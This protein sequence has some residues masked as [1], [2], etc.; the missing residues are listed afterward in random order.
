MRAPQPTSV[1]HVEPLLAEPV[2]LRAGGVAVATAGAVAAR[3]VRWRTAE[4][5]L[6][7]ATPGDVLAAVR[8]TSRTRNSARVGPT[9]CGRDHWCIRAS[10]AL[11]SRAQATRRPL[12]DR[13]RS[14]GVRPSDLVSGATEPREPHRAFPSP[15]LS[16]SRRTRPRRRD[17]RRPPGHPGGRG[18]DAMARRSRAV[19]ERS[20]HDHTG[21][22][23]GPRCR[24]GVVG[25]VPPAWLP[26]WWQ[27]A[28][29]APVWGSIAPSAG[30]AASRPGAA[31]PVD[32]GPSCG[33]PRVPTGSRRRRR[34]AVG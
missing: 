16:G 22:A 2:R 9:G 31:T 32:P 5:G 8:T 6:V 21:R 27:S 34:S 7:V 15:A 20:V 3:T 10:G 19:G 14:T 24:H 29:F 17:E 30:T 28:G 13:H 25:R 33:P 26:S 18:T 23:P 1:T 11:R 12:P 4:R